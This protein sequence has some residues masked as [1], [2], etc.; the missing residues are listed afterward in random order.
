[1][2]NVHELLLLE[3]YSVLDGH[4][5]NTSL[6]YCLQACCCTLCWVCFT[7]AR[8]FHPLLLLS[9]LFVA[10]LVALLS[11]LLVALLGA[12]LGA[13]SLAVLLCQVSTSAA[14][15]CL[16]LAACAVTAPAAAAAV[17]V[18]L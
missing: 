14:A 9:T 15:L 16:Q 5:S 11:T 1:V 17:D 12:L 4:L 6:G 7:G 2:Q 3:Q 18:A 13:V 8:A 10:L